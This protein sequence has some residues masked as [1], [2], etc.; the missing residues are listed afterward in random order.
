MGVGDLLWRTERR[1]KIRKSKAYLIPRLGWPAGSQA[2]NASGY[3]QWTQ[4]STES[5]GSRGRDRQAPASG[6]LGSWN[7]ILIKSALE[8]QS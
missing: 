5:P 3:W 6:L 2:E 8:Q 4:S 1:V 7:E